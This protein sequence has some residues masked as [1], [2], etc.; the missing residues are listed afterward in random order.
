MYAWRPLL[1][2]LAAI[3]VLLSGAAYWTVRRPRFANIII[4]AGLFFAGAWVIQLRPPHASADYSALAFADGRDLVVTG[5]VIKEEN[6]R[7]GSQGDVQ[8]RIDLQL[9]GVESE[10]QTFIAHSRVR[11]TLYSKVLR[12]EA[13]EAMA[14]GA[15]QQFYYGQRLRVFT[16]LYPPHNYRDPGAFDYAAFLADEGIVALASAKIGDVQVL[17]GFSGNRLELW[18][19][20]LRRSVIQRIQLLWKGQQAALIDALFV[21]ENESVGRE[22]LAD[23]QRTGTYHV[24]VISGLKVGVLAMFTFWLL[25]RMRAPN[26]AASAITI[27]LLIAYALLTEVGVPVWRATLMLA[28]YQVARLLYRDRSVLNTIGAAA[29]ALLIVDPTALFGASF[30][31]SFLCVSIIA[32]IGCPILD[33]ST[34]PLIGALRSLDAAGYDFALAPKLVQFRLDLRMIVGR[35]QLF[36]G[37]K[38]PI[39]IFSQGGRLFLIGCEFLAIS[40]VLQV[41]FAMPMAYYFHRAT[42]VSLPA[43]ILAVPLTEI[44]MIGAILALGV[45]CL[46]LAIAKIPAIVAGVAVEAMAGSVRWFGALR[47][48][49][50]RVA[51]PSPIVILLCT[52]AI[53]IATALARRR[54]L[55]AA[56]GL[57]TLAFSAWWICFV[58]P[59]P[60]FRAGAMEVTAIDVG[61]GDSILVVSPDGRTLLIDAGGIPHWMHSELDIGED[62]VSP[63]LWSRGFHQLDA[64]VLSHAH[65]DHIGGMGAVLA[66]FHPKEL[67]IGVDTPSPELTNLLHRAKDLQIPVLLRKAGDRFEAE[68]LE[69]N[70]LAP[71][72]DAVSRA[73][74]PNDDCLVMTVSYGGTTA[75]LEGD[76]EKEAERKIATEQPRADLLKVAHHGS[77]SSTT[78]QLLAA[79]RPQFAVISVGIRNVYGHPRREVLD[80]LG[81]FKIRTY[82]TDIDGATTFYLDGKNVTPAESR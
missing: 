44:A 4:L 2:W 62:V 53:V 36:I 58:P 60:H 67:W 10:G 31:L 56:L 59:H 25:R 16:R 27:V 18:R 19:T 49:D 15:Q 34:R 32:G 75:L 24:L 9:E 80:R 40:L 20:G 43:N 69:F 47:V 5:H 8:Q 64:V 72:R 65:A 22:L 51:T 68:G 73:W 79:V 63:Y 71:A 12:G 21:G 45:S 14:P 78:P 38:I 74:R 61:Q 77:A 26:F 35:L 57:L 50:V 81:E 54:A 30:Q 1:W 82:R 33:R 76:A 46:S 6:G 37:R 23:F 3:T 11:L 39:F 48:A 13:S 28:I 55:L 41:G 17:P 66:N 7:G 52:L 29:M 70:V 42:L